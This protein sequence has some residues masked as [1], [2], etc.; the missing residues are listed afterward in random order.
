[1][2][3]RIGFNADPDLGFHLNADEDPDPVSK[4]NAD[5]DHDRQTLKIILTN[6]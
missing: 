1:M 6:S 4:T 2:W 3:I 5:P